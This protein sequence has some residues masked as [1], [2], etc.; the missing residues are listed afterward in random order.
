MSPDDS[1][2]LS[3]A[4]LLLRPLAA[5]DDRLL[6]DLDSDSE[7]MRWLSGG[8]GTPLEVVRERV[9]PAFLALPVERGFGCWCVFEREST[10]FLGWVTLRPGESPNDDGEL[11]YRFRRDAW[12]RGFAT[13]AASVVL[14][15]AFEEMRLPRVFGTT[16]EANRGSRRVMEKLGMVLVRRFRPGAEELASQATYQPGD[17]DPWDGDDVEYAIDRT[18]WL[19]SRD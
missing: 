4:R 2:E 6:F 5:A 17:D 3:T 12:G 15:R 10:K 11:G 18:G 8:P 14:A 16:Y 1:N 7:V 13:E 9:I 19:R